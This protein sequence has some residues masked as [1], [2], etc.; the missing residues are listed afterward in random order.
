LGTGDEPAMTADFKR[1]TVAIVGGSLAGLATATEL[2]RVTNADITVFEQ[3]AGRLEGR[4]VGIVMQPEIERLL[5]ISGIQPATVS[6]PLRERQLLH[7]HSPPRIFP[8]PQTMTAWD[9]LYRALRSAL[10]GVD[11]RRGIEV[12][13]VTPGE[14][15]ATLTFPD[16]S[17][18]TWRIVIGADGIGS[19]VRQSVSPAQPEYSGYVAWR[20]LEKRMRLPGR[21][22]ERIDRPV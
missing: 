7:L 4:G 11:Y 8:Q 18:S 9:T 13:A 1:W 10:R 20:G 17:T 16:G 15:G 19:T 21:H 5:S 22:H 2:S 14:Q 6:V 3:T 12:A